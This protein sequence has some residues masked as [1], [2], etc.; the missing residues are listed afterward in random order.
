MPAEPAA[1]DGGLFL[2]QSGWAVS[3]VECGPD[4]S[5]VR[6]SPLP[7]G[8]G[9][10]GRWGSDASVVA[11][12]FA[13]SAGAVCDERFRHENSCCSALCVVPN[14]GDGERAATTKY[15]DAAGFCFFG[16]CHGIHHIQID[17]SKKKGGIC[18]AKSGVPGF[19]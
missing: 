14:A 10:E 1:V 11:T 6:R 17:H 2:L 4:G 3:A 5:R 12:A 9:R 16:Y 7:D 19:F 13:V 8:K 18:N 15:Y